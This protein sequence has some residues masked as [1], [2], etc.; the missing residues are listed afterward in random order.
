MALDGVAAGGH[1]AGLREQGGEAPE[2]AGAVCAV[3]E[4]DV[5]D[6]LGLEARLG[7][8]AA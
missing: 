1:W 7:D 5:F 3:A 4:R 2:V 8:S 6:G